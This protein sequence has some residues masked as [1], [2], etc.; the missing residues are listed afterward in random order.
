MAIRPSALFSMVWDLVMMVIGV[1]KF[2]SETII[3][4][5]QGI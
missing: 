2:W 5:A 1:V 4:D 3:S